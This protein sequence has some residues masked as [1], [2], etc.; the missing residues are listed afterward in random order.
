MKN[1]IFLFVVFLGATKV[2]AQFDPEAEVLLEKMSEKYQGKKAFT[3]GFNQN[4]INEA[5][6]INENIEGIIHV[7]GDKY[8]LEIAGQI[9]FNDSENIWSYNQEAKEVTVT[10]YDP[11]EEEISL[12]N[13]WNLYKQGYKYGLNENDSEGNWVV[14]LE[15]IKRGSQN[16]YKIRMS[17]SPSIDLLGFVIFEDSGNK[18]EYVINQ[19]RDRSD[20]NDDFFTFDLSQYPGVELI[21]F[22]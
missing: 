20:L 11:E 9:I 7:K 12:N 15:P 21:D 10:L 22:R 1:I 3:S 5:S 17:I 14:D 13:I 19:L 2:L 4:L 8:R 18:F 16:F 6:N